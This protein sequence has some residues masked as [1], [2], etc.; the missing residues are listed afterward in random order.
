MDSLSKALSCLKL[1][2]DTLVN[3]HVGIHRHT[4]GKDETGNTRKGQHGSKSRKN[5][6]QENHVG[7]KCRVSSQTCAL[8]EEYHVDKDEKEGDDE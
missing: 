7:K 8:I 1:F 2:L 6:E 3:N 4:Q 5:A